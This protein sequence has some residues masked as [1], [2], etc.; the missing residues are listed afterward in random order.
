MPTQATAGSTHS[1]TSGWL[2]KWAP[3][4]ML[5]GQ[6]AAPLQ[7][8][9]PHER[10]TSCAF[11]LACNAAASSRAL[12]THRAVGAPASPPPLH[13]LPSLPSLAQ[14]PSSLALAQVATP[15]LRAD[16]ARARA[17]GPGGADTSSALGAALW[18]DRACWPDRGSCGRK[19][20]LSS[21]GSA[22][23][24]CTSSTS[25]PT[26]ALWSLP[27]NKPAARTR[28]GPHVGARVA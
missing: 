18:P 11:S 21:R 1:C 8:E 20:S 25:A 12:A 23:C 13:P 14:T 5:S 4:H 10:T 27:S 16:T 9:V 2:H 6:V 3:Q 7:V 15:A 22:A 17:S 19:G 24:A 28:Q 26:H